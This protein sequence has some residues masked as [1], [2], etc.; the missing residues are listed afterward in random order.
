MITGKNYI[1]NKLSAQGSTKYSTINPVLNLENNWKSTEATVEEI[2]E[3]TA[4]SSKAFK[5]FRKTTP[6][7]RATFLEAIADEIERLGSELIEIYCLESGLPQGRAEGERGRTL[8][9]L[10]SFD[11]FSNAFFLRA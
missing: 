9:Q 7:Q 4:L 11:A 6:D 2:A 5:D 1:G 8:F 3:A 10:R